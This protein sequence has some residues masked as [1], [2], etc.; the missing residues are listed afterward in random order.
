MLFN[1]IEFMILFLPVTLGLFYILPARARLY[2]LLVMS[3]IFYASAGLVPF[4]FMIAGIVWV[5]VVGRLP[6]LSDRT[7][8]LLGISFP[9]ASLILLRYLDFIFDT[10]NM[11]DP[12]R[13]PFMFFLSVAL[14]AGISFY[15]FQMMC[16]IVD[17]RRKN[18]PP[19]SFLILANYISFFPQ[20]IAGPILRISQIQGQF[21][22]IHLG[23]LR[24]DFPHACK[25]IAFGLAVKVFMADRIAIALRNFNP[26]TALSTVD[27]AYVLLAYSMRIYLDFWAYS[28]IAVGLGAMLSIWIPRNFLEP[29]LS[30]NPKIFWQRWHVTLSYWIRDYIYFPLGGNRHYIRNI[31][32]VFAAVGLWHGAGW[33]FILWGIY[34]GC[35][36][37]FYKL[38]GG[39]WDRMPA[40]IQR[41][42]T[43]ILV[44]I[45][46]PLFFLDIGQYA[47]FM[48]DL[49]SFGKFMPRNFTIMDWAI[50][51]ITLVWVFGQR[52][53]TWL[54]PEG[55]QGRR[56]L[57]VLANNF[58]IQGAMIAAAIAFFPWS[59]TFIYFRF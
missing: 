50:L 5:Y 43:F 59:S 57:N 4:Y 19:P 10:F 37:S 41:G 23:E 35:L 15:S 11:P 17:L 31:L 36:V 12:M 26:D 44:S 39:R 51:A 20:L 16:Y 6:I 9:L 29:Y 45:A 34:H 42:L 27:S 46:W 30:L 58:L 32:I 28:T 40:L 1:S 14:P 3:W 7:A 21:K 52:E 53:A 38:V 25:L 8:I 18:Q 13:E 47:T 49:V 24:S 33:N 56:P 54:Y 55:G 48:A 22:R 2:L